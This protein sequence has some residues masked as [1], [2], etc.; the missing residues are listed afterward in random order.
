VFFLLCPSDGNFAGFGEPAATPDDIQSSA[1]PV[2][3]IGIGNAVLSGRPSVFVQEWYVGERIGIGE[4]DI[5]IG[6][7]RRAAKVRAASRDGKLARPA[8]RRKSMPGFIPS[9]II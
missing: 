1:I 5:S 6:E 7:T 9:L 3:A 4:Q 8:M 2:A